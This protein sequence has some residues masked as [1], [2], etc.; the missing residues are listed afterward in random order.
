MSHRFSTNTAEAPLCGIRLAGAALPADA[1]YRRW[2]PSATAPLLLSSD[3]VHVWLASLHGASVERFQRTLS[4]DEQNRAGRFRFQRDRR[5][6][7][8]ARGLLRLILS[9]YLGIEPVRLRFSYGR[10]GKPSLA[11]LSSQ[12]RLTF[13]LSRCGGRALLAVSRNRE[14]GIDLERIRTDF[15]CRQ[16]AQQ[17]FSSR[18]NAMLQ[19]LRTEQAR[20]TAFFVAWARKEAYVKARGDGLA[21]P[22]SRFDVS[23]LPGEPAKLLGMR[24]N[25]LETSRWSLQ[26]IHTGRGYVAALAVEGHGWY[27]SYRDHHVHEA[28]VG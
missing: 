9:Y 10:H 3:D 23:L 4:T 25:P 13:N 22:L 6:F 28:A 26:D 15:P 17:F 18:E 14:V 20:R 11:I 8:V 16:I 19:S 7:I 24:G 5:R 12:D 21:L 2:L 27:L 1:I